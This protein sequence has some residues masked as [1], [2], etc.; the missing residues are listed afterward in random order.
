MKDEI[1]LLLLEEGTDVFLLVF[2]AMDTFSDNEEIQKYGC[3]ALH[4]LLE[5]ETIILQVIRESVPDLIALSD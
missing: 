1:T 3:Q 4:M 5:K 2:D